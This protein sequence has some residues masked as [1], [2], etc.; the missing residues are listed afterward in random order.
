MA[1][2]TH[3]APQRQKWTFE[4]PAQGSWSTPARVDMSSGL[5]ARSVLRAP[6]S[7]TVTVMD[8]RVWHGT[9]YNESTDPAAVPEE[10][11]VYSR[12]AISTAG[13]ATA[14]DDDYNILLNKDGAPFVNQ[15]QWRDDTQ[16][17]G[18][19]EAHYT[20]WSVKSVTA[21]GAQA[22]CTLVLESV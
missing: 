7:S 2:N 5:L 6:P 20:W 15:R 21:S 19:N 14:A 18:Q 17:G 4:A 22:G 1:H 3:R 12:T 9:G 8:I 16:T 11:I 13:S 10:D